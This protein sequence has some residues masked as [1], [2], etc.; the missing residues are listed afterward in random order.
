M[1]ATKIVIWQSH[2]NLLQEVL[3]QPIIRNVTKGFHLR[4][5][6]FEKTKFECLFYKNATLTQG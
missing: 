2:A 4:I 6:W 3:I 1:V 5:E